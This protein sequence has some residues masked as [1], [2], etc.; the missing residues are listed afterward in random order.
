VAR[1]GKR[2]RRTQQEVVL[3]KQVEEVV[4]T[5]IKR[6]DRLEHLEVKVGPDGKVKFTY[7]IRA[8]VIEDSG[9]L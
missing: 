9:E 3:F 1:K 6:I 2:G 7:R 4:Q 5:V 8:E